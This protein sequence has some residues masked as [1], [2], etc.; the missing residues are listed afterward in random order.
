MKRAK[1]RAWRASQF[2]HRLW[3]WALESTSS[4][5]AARLRSGPESCRGPEAIRGKLGTAETTSL[6]GRQRQA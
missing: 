3:G 4:M 1:N 5:P 6:A 2:W